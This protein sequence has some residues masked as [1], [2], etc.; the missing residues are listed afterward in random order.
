MATDV[1]VKDLSAEVRE[2]IS[3]L[4]QTAGVEKSGV[5]TRIGD[6]VAWI[7]GLSGAG[8]SEMLEID[9]V[10]GE[11]VNAFALNLM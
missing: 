10:N 7:Y 8:Y 4:K 6:G 1:S 11:T 2:A 3:Q 5:V 9:G